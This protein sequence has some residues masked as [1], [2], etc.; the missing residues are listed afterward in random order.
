MYPVILNIPED[1]SKDEVPADKLELVILYES[2]QY[3]GLKMSE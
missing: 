1:E 2:M 3:F